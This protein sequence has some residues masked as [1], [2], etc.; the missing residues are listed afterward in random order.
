MPMN[1]LERLRKYF[2]FMKRRDMLTANN[3]GMVL[4]LLW[5]FGCC[6]STINST[7]TSGDILIFLF[8]LCGRLSWLPVRNK[9][10]YFISVLYNHITAT[11]RDDLHWLPM[12]Q[13]I[14]YKLCTIVYKCLHGV[15][16]SYLTEMCVPVA[17]SIGRRCLRSA[18]RGAHS[19]NNN[20][21]ITEFCSLRTTCLEW[22]ATNFA[23]FIHHT[24]A[25]PKQTKDNT[26]SLGLRDM[27]WRFR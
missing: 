17:A 16:P 22:S 10:T 21:W 5:V 27:T 15:A 20:V 6:G 25:V 7:T 3:D 2:S 19:E 8:I 18:A 1:E 13:R 11:L 23:F 12:R 9:L 24:R 14:T 4:V 26:I